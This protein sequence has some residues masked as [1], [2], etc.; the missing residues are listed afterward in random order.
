MKPAESRYFLAIIPPDPIQ[1]EAQ[2][3]KVQFR[4][5][6]NS[7]G[8][9]RSPAH[10]TLHM[11]FQWKEKKEDKLFSLLVQATNGE[12]FHLSFDGFGAFP[13]RTIFIKN[14]MSQDL[15]YFQER[16]ARYAKR[17]MNL[18]NA[19]HNRGYHPHM[20][21]AFRDLKKDKFFEAWAEFEDKPFDHEFEVNSF[22]LLKHDGKR[23]NAYREFQFSE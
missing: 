22:W 20:T 7:K 16:L 15:M 8:A 21:V 13:P 2:K 14:K 17:N 12:K 11:P 10:I 18:F 9:L 19:T 4:D 5:D 3:I 1:S 23:W 6:F